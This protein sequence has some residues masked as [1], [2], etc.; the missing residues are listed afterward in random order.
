LRSFL[1]SQA[2]AE[3]GAELE[4]NEEDSGEEE[5]DGGVVR[6]VMEVSGV[7]EDESDDEVQEASQNVDD[8]RG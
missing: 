8:G 6:M 2:F 3:P 7:D 4:G 1:L 5:D